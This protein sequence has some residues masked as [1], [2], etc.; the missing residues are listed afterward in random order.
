M[1][2]LV[3]VGDEE[4]ETGAKGR[5]LKSSGL[6]HVAV[7]GVHRPSQAIFQPRQKE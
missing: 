2:L 5:T 7:F 1:F 3:G 6:A 4:A